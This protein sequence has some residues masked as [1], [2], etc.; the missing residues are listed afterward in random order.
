[1]QRPHIVRFVAV[2]SVLSALAFSSTGA[3][4][5]PALPEPSEHVMR[6][7]IAAGGAD[8]ADADDNVASEQVPASLARDIV[9]RYAAQPQDPQAM[10]NLA[11]LNLALSVAQWGVSSASGELPADPAKMKWA[12][13][14]QSGDGKHVLS[15]ARGGVGL[16]HMDAGSLERLYD[17]LQSRHS[18]VV[19]PQYRQAFFGLKGKRFDVLYA[20]GGNCTRPSTA[21][22]L[23]LD[24]KPFRHRGNGYAGDK[25]CNKY[26]GK[27]T[28]PTDWQVFRHGMREALR[29]EDV[30]FWIMRR[31]V[32]SYWWPSQL[33]VQKISGWQS[34]DVMVNSR[35]RNSSSKEAVCAWNAAKTLPTAAQRVERQLQMYVECSKNPRMAERWPFMRRLP[36]LVATFSGSL[37][38]LKTTSATPADA[39]SQVQVAPAPADMTVL[40][41]KRTDNKGRG[42]PRLAGTRNFRTVLPGVVYRGGVDGSKRPLKLAPDSANDHAARTKAELDRAWNPLTGEAL[43]NLCQEGFGTAVYLYARNYRDAAKETRC[44][45][46]APSVPGAAQRTLRYLSRP[47]FLTVETQRELL[48][49]VHKELMSEKPQPIY[50]HCWNGW[51]AS[52]FMSAL[53]L[54]QFCGMSAADAADYWKKASD[55]PVASEDK[56]LSAIRRFE[57]LPAMSISPEVKK[58]VCP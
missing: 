36:V 28:T 47:T 49:M 55:G 14:G 30:Q 54:R 13:T 3:S 41:K 2:A 34:A 4:A 53:V 46:M 16:A 56:L 29:H 10:G 58:R 21:I 45:D 38:T 27:S 9:H 25:Y 43:S 8:A 57:P 5:Q 24:G 1:M 40:L 37:P 19:P 32:H 39:V 51:H 15:Y 18:D 52:G 22:P 12:G 23:D 33:E 44:T 48:S 50:L 6:Q 35:I 17:Y 26:G 42:D 31:W 7:L 11:L 20:G